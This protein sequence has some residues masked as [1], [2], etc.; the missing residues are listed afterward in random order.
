MEMADIK[1]L[2]IN[3]D[4]QMMIGSSYTLLELLIQ[5]KMETPKLIEIIQHFS[6]NKKIHV[7]AIPMAL[8][9]K[10][11]IL[12]YLLKNQYPLTNVRNIDI[13]QAW[14]SLKPDTQRFFNGKKFTPKYQEKVKM[15]KR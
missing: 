13:C 8:N 12:D 14:D 7:H 10:S 1:K 4:Y 2:K 11:S 5:S 15:V 3:L 9:Q 6:V